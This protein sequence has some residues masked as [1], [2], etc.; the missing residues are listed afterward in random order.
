[1]KPETPLTRLSK[2]DPWTTTDIPDDP[3]TIATVQR[4]VDAMRKFEKSKSTNPLGLVLSIN[5]IRS[6]EGGTTSFAFSFHK[7]D[8][9]TIKLLLL[10]AYLIGVFFS[11][12]DLIDWAER[13]ACYRRLTPTGQSEMCN[14][15]DA[16]SAS[17]TRRVAAMLESGHWNTPTNAEDCRDGLYA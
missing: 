14:L 10:P 12:Y 17:M 4:A 11:I 5:S 15:I 1:M 6:N 8:S 9:M 3:Q 2:L 13:V 7:K 16:H